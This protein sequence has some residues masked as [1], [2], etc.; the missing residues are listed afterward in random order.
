MLRD[1][2]GSVRAQRSFSDYELI[3]VSNGESNPQASHQV[4]R[5]YACKFIQ[6]AKGNR[7]LARNIAIE[8]ARGEWIAFLDDDD[9]WHRNKLVLQLAFAA[10]TGADCVFTDFVLRD[11]NT[12]I[13]R[14]HHI[15]PVNAVRCK[16]LS[17]PESF[18]VWRAGTGGCSTALIR[19]QVL[20]DLGCF[21]T[22]M[23]LCEDWD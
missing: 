6:L 4:A 1:A 23:V 16:G 15:A 11:V 14:N 18:M 20:L 12:G 7:S 13:E 3:A 5:Q 8:Q 22:K 2:V 17:A 10:D 21:D 19:R 9:L